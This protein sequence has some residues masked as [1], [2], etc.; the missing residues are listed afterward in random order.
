MYLIG[1]LILLANNLNLNKVTKILFELPH[2]LVS[3]VVAIFTP[4]LR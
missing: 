2:K 3:S 1:V 4:D